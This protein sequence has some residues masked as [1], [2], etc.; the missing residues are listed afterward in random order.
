MMASMATRD[1]APG[2]LLVVALTGA[3]AAQ[4][5][6]PAVAPSAAAERARL[7]Q[8]ARQVIQKARYATLTTVGEDGHPQARIVDPFP[9]ED[10]MVVWIATN[11]RTRKVAQIRREARVS[12]LY[13]DAAG[14]S[15]VT[16]LGRAELVRDPAQK[17]RWW[18]EEWA[19]F[20]K[21]RNRGDD[22]LLLRVKP[23]RLEIVSERDGVVNDPQTWQ[24]VVLEMK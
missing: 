11:A 2:L 20:Y 17:A 5:A 7:L 19:A 24:P 10:G 18:K 16:L 3:A 4:D 22:Y 21:D 12:L 9:A 14:P 1:W 6:A 13:F 15:Y 8:V 23:T